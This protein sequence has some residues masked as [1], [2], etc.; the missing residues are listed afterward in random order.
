M[1]AISICVIWH[2]RGKEV[3]KR[4]VFV[5][6]IGWNELGARTTHIENEFRGKRM[7]A[8]CEVS[9]LVDWRTRGRH[10]KMCRTQSCHHVCEQA[11]DTFHIGKPLSQSRA[12]T[13][14]RK[15][16]PN[17]KA[18]TNGHILNLYEYSECL[19]RLLFFLLPT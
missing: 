6:L 13:I 14:T 17:G 10:G 12:N 16:E 5:A 8:S 9:A 15:I 4:N 2:E 1:Y 11:I 18:R 19:S 7:T 3:P